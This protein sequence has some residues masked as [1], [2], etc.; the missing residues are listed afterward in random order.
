MKPAQDVSDEFLS[1]FVDD[2]LDVAEKS[3]AFDLIEQDETLRRR[4]Q[5]GAEIGGADVVHWPDDAERRHWRHL[6][7]GQQRRRR[8]R[9][10]PRHR[11]RHGCWPDRCRPGGVPRERADW[12]RGYHLAEKRGILSA[13]GQRRL[14][15]QDR[16]AVV[17]RTSARTRVSQRQRR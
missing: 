3:Q 16:G 5:P 13:D 17:W 6:Q 10:Q 2:Q 15:G 11:C 7:S 14:A 9:H 12:I 4:D 1:A 8:I